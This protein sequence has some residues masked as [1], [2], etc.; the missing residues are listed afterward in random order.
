MGTYLRSSS[1]CV[2]L[3]ESREQQPPG[4]PVA[5]EDP[6]QCQPAREPEVPMEADQ[7]GEEP[8]GVTRTMSML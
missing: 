5:S 4:P 3:E 7:Q 8:V 6:T 2:P 1:I